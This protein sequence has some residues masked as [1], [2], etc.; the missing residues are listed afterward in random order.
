MTH[1]EFTTVISNIGLD[2][3][4]D[5]FT[6]DTEHKLPFICFIYPNR[7]DLTADNTNYQPIES[8]RVELYTQEWDREQEAAVGT[9]LN[10]AGLAYVLNRVFLDDERMWMATFDTSFV[11][12]ESEETENA[13]GE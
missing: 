7:I 6:D 5:H 3:A 2:Y 12:T 13:D 1:A 10:E 4:Y 8:V 9:A 11:L